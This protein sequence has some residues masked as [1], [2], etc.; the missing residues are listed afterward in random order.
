MLYLEKITCW[1]E[2]VPWVQ[3]DHNVW[4][5]NCYPGVVGSSG[6]STSM[7][8]AHDH[9][10]K[11]ERQSQQITRLVT[12]QYHVEDAAEPVVSSDSEAVSHEAYLFGEVVS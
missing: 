6:S 8:S 11:V 5:L 10:D 9:D 1:M 3:V 12:S 2:N 7:R 4:V